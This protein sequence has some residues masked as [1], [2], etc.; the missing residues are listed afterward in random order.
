M[1]SE[2]EKDLV[3]SQAVKA[4]KRIYYFDV[5]QSRN[6][7]R[8]VSITESKKIVEGSVENP[9]VSFEKH[10]IFLYKEDYDKF[11]SAMLKTLDIARTGYVPEG[12]LDNQDSR[13]FG[14]RNREFRPYNR[15]E[16][17]YR[18]FDQAD[19]V[20][21]PAVQEEAEQPA[22]PQPVQSVAES[23]ET[24]AIVNEAPVSADK[25]SESSYKID[26]DF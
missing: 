4:G 3:F 21:E 25:T 5:K 22:A 15:L 7:D 16:R 24:P 26:L 11:L 12:Y 23:V 13:Q 9:Q 14:N 10:K 18:R 8:Y 6:G 1:M 2:L 19:S 20:A 17:D